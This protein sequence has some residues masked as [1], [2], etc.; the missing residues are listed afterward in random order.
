MS[1]FIDSLYT[2]AGLGTFLERHGMRLSRALGQHFFIHRTLLRKFL[3]RFDVT[4]ENR[5]VEIGPGMGHLTALLLEN[6]AAVTAIEKDKRF[7]T[8]LKEVIAQVPEWWPRCDIRVQDA[9]DVDFFA[10]QEETAADTC[11]GNLPYNVSVPLLFRLAYSGARFSRLGFLVQKEV[12]ERMTARCGEKAYGRLSIVLQYLFAI[13]LVGNAPP[14]AFF[15]PPKVQSLFV[16]M[17]PRADADL[18]FAETYLERVVRIGFLH[19]RKKLR[20]HMRGAIVEK[21]VFDD[22]FLE[23]ASE[24]FD[25]EGRAEHWDHDTWVRFARFVRDTPPA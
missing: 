3:T 11:I 19:R 8:M 10:L 25:L 20:G 23:R 15:P 21:R 16:R 2:R 4:N 7:A 5:V 13:R 12:G 1:E 24:Q 17:E 22:A 14:K 6:G 9:M 18:A